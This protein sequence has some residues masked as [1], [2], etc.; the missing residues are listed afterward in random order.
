[1]KAVAKTYELA[2]L[3]E[4][5][6]IMTALSH[7]CS[8][9]IKIRSPYEKA[10]IYR[11]SGDLVLEEVAEPKIESPTDA[12]IKVVTS[13]ICGSD[14]HIKE[15][16]TQKPGKIIGHE[17]FSVIVETGDKVHHFKKGDRVVGKIFYNCGHC[18]SCQQAATH[19]V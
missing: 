14:I 19:P 6:E 9:E 12:L 1:M 17:C 2:Y 11:E 10:V 3:P 13:A 15:L 16:G 18:F 7:I 8:L 5:G 4:N